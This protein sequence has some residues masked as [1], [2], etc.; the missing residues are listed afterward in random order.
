MTS[1]EIKPMLGFALAAIMITSIF[2]TMAPAGSANGS[3]QPGSITNLQNVT[4]ATWIN[5]MWTNPADAD[6]YHTMVFLNGKW[7]TNTSDSFY[8][9]TD[10]DQDTSYEIGTHTVDSAGN[11]NETWVNQTGRTKAVPDT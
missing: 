4:G 8:N 9:A 7:E 11:V 6:F 2:V 3:T 10:L 1:K 5:W